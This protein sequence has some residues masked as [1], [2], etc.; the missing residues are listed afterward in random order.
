MAAIRYCG[1]LK[2]R[3]T[4]VE[5]DDT[6][7]VAFTEIYDDARFKTLTDL[8]LS[9]FERARTAGDSSRAYDLIA[10]SAISFA[11]DEDDAIYRFAFCDSDSGEAIISRK[12]G[13]PES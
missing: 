9:A 2:M 13:V 7:R 4:Y 6:Y 3:I 5:R 10:K 11:A 8:R 1:T 12:L